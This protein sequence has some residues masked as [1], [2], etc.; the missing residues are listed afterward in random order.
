MHTLKTLE[1]LP[2]KANTD[3][4]TWWPLA[5][6]AFEKLGLR[7]PRLGEARDAFEVGESPETFAGYASGIDNWNEEYDGW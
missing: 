5:V 7:P 3:F 4:F 6:T 2:T 1:T